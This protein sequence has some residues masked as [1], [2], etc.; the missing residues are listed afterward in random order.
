MPKAAP[1]TGFDLGPL[2]K[3]VLTWFADGNYGAASQTLAFW[4]AFNVRRG[5]DSHPTN[6][7]SFGRCLSLLEEVPELRERLPLMKTC[8]PQWS[9][10]V[11]QWGEIEELHK[12]EFTSIRKPTPK[13]DALL[14]KLC[15]KI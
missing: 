10:I 9:C 4:A 15:E 1:V 14:K 11:D 6:G 2:A 12:V 7:E 5:G 13:V 3:K 8:S